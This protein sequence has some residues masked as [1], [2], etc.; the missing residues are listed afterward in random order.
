MKNA[1]RITLLLVTL[2]LVMFLSACGSADMYTE[3]IG[4]AGGTG[5][6]QW[7]VTKAAELT[8]YISEFFGGYYFIGLIVVTLLV[9]TLGWPIYAKSNA[10]TFNMQ[11]AQPE[12]EKLREKYQGK[13]DEA[14]QKKMQAETLEIYRKYKINPL[15]C[16]LPFLQMPIF[17]AMY[18]VVRRIPL[19]EQFADLNY[20]FLWLNLKTGAGN[21]NFGMIDGDIILAVLVGL[22]MFFYQRFAMKKPD[23]MQNK[24]YQ[25]AQA[26]QSQ[27][28]TKMMSYFMVFML[29]SIAITNSGIALY[30]V[31]GNLYQFL[32][33][34]MNRKTNEKK[35]L[36]SQ[37]RI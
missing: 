17:I 23:Y 5:W 32:Q 28:T 13:T 31:V 18:Q 37:E 30:W 2:S 24:K 8:V 7:I 1:T 36:E 22:I 4:A 16:L 34:Y 21:I 29:V 12:L 25:T 9:R 10:M 33:T 15:G 35:H 3:P 14:S 19:S 11:Q 20:N 6:I 27:K 26:T